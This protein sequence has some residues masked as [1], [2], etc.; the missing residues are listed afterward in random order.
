[1]Y[2]GTEI[3][4]KQPFYCIVSQKKENLETT[5]VVKKI[6]SK[7]D[8]ENNKNMLISKE[9]DYYYKHDNWSKHFNAFTFYFRSLTLMNSI[10]ITTKNDIL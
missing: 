9:N 5:I 1:M 2:L 4:H 3:K 10:C 8:D 6:V 7:P